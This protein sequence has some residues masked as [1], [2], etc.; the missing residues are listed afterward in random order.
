[1]RATVHAVDAADFA[2]FRPLFAPL[3][4]AGLRASYARGLAGVDPGRPRHGHPFHSG[5]LTR[6]SRAPW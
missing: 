1:M 5:P 3:M 4:T 2:A 6:P